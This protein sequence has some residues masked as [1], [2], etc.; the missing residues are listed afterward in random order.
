VRLSRSQERSSA[1]LSQYTTPQVAE[2]TLISLTM[3][4]GFGRRSD[5]TEPSELLASFVIIQD[6]RK[7][8]A[9][10][11]TTIL[12]PASMQAAVCLSF[13]GNTMHELKPQAADSWKN[14]SSGDM[15]P[16]N[17][18]SHMHSAQP[19]TEVIRYGCSGTWSVL[20]TEASQ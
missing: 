2:L 4:A 3:T 13:Q 1:Y 8:S 18:P 7:L 10:Q 9:T 12:H 17:T 14:R 6:R 15:H 16:D 20:V 19:G 5:V 11:M